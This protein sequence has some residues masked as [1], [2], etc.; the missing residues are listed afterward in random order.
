MTSTKILI[1]KSLLTVMSVISYRI[2]KHPSIC[3]GEVLT[4]SGGGSF[5]HL[6]ITVVRQEGSDCE[7]FHKICRKKSVIEPVFRNVFRLQSVYLDKSGLH[8]VCFPKNCYF[9][10]HF[11][12]AFFSYLTRQ[13]SHDFA[14]QHVFLA[15]FVFHFCLSLYLSL[16]LC[17]KCNFNLT[18][19]FRNQSKV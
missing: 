7:Q 9:L 4:C 5:R 17:I 16:L 11:R 10:K 3:I 6:L 2:K 14:R 8:H 19:T 13:F 15:I 1:N 12:T 18:L